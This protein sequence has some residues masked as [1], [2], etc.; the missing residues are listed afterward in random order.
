MEFIMNIAKVSFIISI[1]SLVLMLATFNINP[2]VITGVAGIP[3]G[4]VCLFFAI[5]IISLLI[6]ILAIIVR[7]VSDKVK[8][9]NK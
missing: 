2:T 1:V 5:F 6:S 9:K 4:H 3:R 8:E 7:A